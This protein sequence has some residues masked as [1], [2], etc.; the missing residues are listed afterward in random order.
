MSI[1]R[2][3][4]GSSLIISYLAA[5]LFFSGLVV[6]VVQ[7]A[8]LLLIWPFSRNA[9]RRLN[10]SLVELYWT[11]L[12]F[13]AE[14]WANVR[15]ST[16]ASKEVYD[17]ISRDRAVFLCNHGSDLD[18]L[19]GWQAA[20]KF[21]LLGGSKCLL[22]KSLSYIPVLGWTWWFLEYVFLSR[23]WAEDQKLMTKA[24]RRL[25]EFN[26]PY[27]MVIFAEGTRITP[28]KYALSVEHCKANNLP[29]FKHV[30]YPRVKGW[31][32]VVQELRNSLD[33]VYVATYAFPPGE[34]PSVAD[35]LEGKDIDI[36]IHITRTPIKDLP[37]DT[38]A[39]EQW[40][41]DAFAGMDERLS[42][43]KDTG[44]WP[45]PYIESPHQRRLAP[46]IITL[47]WMTILTG[48]LA[49]VFLPSLLAGDLYAFAWLGLGF[50]VGEV[51]IRVLVMFARKSKSKKK[52][53][54]RKPKEN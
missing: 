5:V 34:P 6:N 19:I 32:L 31:S 24:F 17:N 11:Q 48:I 42:C 28:E 25:G 12:I 23:S 10:G 41:V 53:S 9:Y 14:W 18:W 4:G 43:L 2:V 3:L 22:K 51:F 15:V 36:R 54:S 13:L 35:L 21:G 1:G 52:P 33:S 29:V 45:Q 40:C 26:M 39:V 16:F 44:S 47:A 46:L 8:S 49:S 50:L 20:Y 37:A 7:L 30:M 38:A 27:W